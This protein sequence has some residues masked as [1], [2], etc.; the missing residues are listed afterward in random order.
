LDHGKLVIISA[1][2]YAIDDKR[3]MLKEPLFVIRSK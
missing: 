1:V 3:A 2:E